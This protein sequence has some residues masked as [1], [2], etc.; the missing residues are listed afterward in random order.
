[1]SLIGDKLFNCRNLTKFKKSIVQVLNFRGASMSHFFLC[2]LAGERFLTKLSFYRKTAK[3]LYDMPEHATNNTDTEIKILAILKE[4]ITDKN[5]SPCI[6]EMVHVTICNDITRLMPVPLK[7]CGDFI[8][9]PEN[10]SLES[11]IDK[12]IC[13]QADLA[14]AGLSYNRC[15]FIV[16]E[17]CDMTLADF[18]RRPS[19]SAVH[20]EIFRSLM[21]QVIYTLYSI[22]KIFPEFH[23]YDLHTENIMILFEPKYVF[24]VKNIKYLKFY[25]DNK[26]VYVPY[27]GMIAKIIDFGFAVLPERNVVSVASFDKIHMYHRSKNDVL[28]LLHH[29]YYAIPNKV[30]SGII[31]EM[32]TQIEPNRTFVEFFTS[33]IR[34]IEHKIPSYKKM[35]KCEAFKGYYRGMPPHARVVHDYDG[36]SNMK[37]PRN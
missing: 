17:K 27:F 28:F 11:D 22:T 26:P 14:R 31:D 8:L 29:I 1:M 6:L 4:V 5:I 33:H 36:V 37:K 19:Y 34:D 23:H 2:E 10:D 12:I 30:G 13:R 32:L 35:V 16:V 20:I 18:L 3:E 21:F 24:D 7:D 25:V 15:A 9:D